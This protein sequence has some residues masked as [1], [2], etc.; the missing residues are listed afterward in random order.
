MGELSL[1]RRGASGPKVQ[2]LSMTVPS[3]NLQSISFT[4]VKINPT[5]IAVI[6]S[7]TWISVGIGYYIGAI[8]ESAAS[9]AFYTTSAGMSFATATFSV[10]N[11]ILT[12]HG[13]DCYQW[14][15]GMK[16]YAI[17]IKD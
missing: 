11:G 5:M 15:A 9:Q 12:V 7:S 3:N 17:L 13:G 2:V 1:V 14:R 16:I 10:N 4:G 8:M 6:P